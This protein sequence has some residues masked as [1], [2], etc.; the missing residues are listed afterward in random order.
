MKYLFSEE[1]LEL[2]KLHCAGNTLIAFDFDGTISKIVKRPED[3]KVDKVSLKLLR[4]ISKIAPVA[5]IS[6]RS[7]ADLKLIFKSLNSKALSCHL[8]GNH[9]IESTAL[10]SKALRSYKKI[11]QEWKK[12]LSDEI[13][14]SADRF[15]GIEIEDKVFSISLHYRN[16]PNKKAA[17]KFLIS[18]IQKL[19][20]KAQ[21]INGKSVFNI[22]PA[23]APD[24]GQA[25]KKLMKKLKIANAI[26]FGDDDTDEDI[27]ALN[28]PK[29]MKVRVGKKNKSKAQFYLKNQ[30]QMRKV[31][32]ALLTIQ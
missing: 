24:K 16:C 9:G 27:F 7:R 26:Y 21:V 31:Y 3:A 10:S 25:L 28:N 22:I 14:E 12:Y 29:I 13:S 15:A 8:I 23:G 30:S 19:T 18:K 6:G 5:I 17:K 2:L 11:C 4:Q 1:N 20:P 32:L